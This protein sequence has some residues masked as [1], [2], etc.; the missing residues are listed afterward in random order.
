MS[1]TAF[2]EPDPSVLQRLL[3]NSVA[4]I[5]GAY[6]VIFALFFWGIHSGLGQYW[7]WSFPYFGDQMSTL[8]TNKS[9]S[10]TSAKMGSP[11][12]YSSDYFVRFVIA[13]FGFL[14]P[15]LTR[16]GLLVI[17]FSVGALGM[18]MLARKCTSGGMAF[19]IGLAAF[20]NPAMFYK[21]TAG[22]FNYFISYVLF[23]YL[24]LF[25]LYKFQKN[26]RSAVIVGLFLAFIGMQIQ[27]FVIGSIFVIVFLAFNR[28]LVAWRYV[29]VMVALPVL[30]N[31]VWLSNFIVGAASVA[32]TGAAATKV[33]F[34]SLGSS[35]F[36][37]IF[38][39]SFSGATLLNRF[40]VFYELLWNAALF[41]FLLW[42]LVREKQKQLIDV[43]L[44]VFLSIM[45][46]M[47]TGLYQTINLG[48]LTALYPMLREVGHF[49]PIIVLIALLLVSR[50]VH[51]TS[52]RWALMGILLGSLLIVGVKFQYY[53]QGYSFAFARSQFA[54]FKKIADK[55]SS[56]YRILAYPFFDQYSFNALPKDAPDTFPL[57]NSGHDSFAG[58]SKQGY[59]NNA[60]AP[61]QFQDSLQNRLLQ[62]YNIDMLKPYNIKYIFDLS[63][64]YESN[65]EKYVPP[66]V[67]NND[68]SLIKN[69]KH[70]LDKLLAKN[71]GKLK[72]LNSHAL[73]VT[74]FSPHVGSAD[75]VFDINTNDITAQSASIFTQEALNKSLN[76][77]TNKSTL[78]PYTTKLTSLFAD[79]AKNKT[80]PQAGTAAQMLKPA[81][82]SRSALYI[83]TSRS[84]VL[85]QA[86]AKELTIYTQ[87][88]GQLSLNGALVYNP[89]TKRRV[90]ATI[91]FKGKDPY[92][93][94]FRG[95]SA[96]I[97]PN[98]QGRLGLGAQGDVITIFDSPGTNAVQN[99]SFEQGLWQRAVHDCNNYRFD[100]GAKLGMQLDTQHT[101][102]GKQALELSATRHNAC[103]STPAKVDPN[104]EYLL[105]FDYQSSDART[106][107]F[108]LG[109]ADKITLA[110]GSQTITN[111]Q[112][113][114]Y[115]TLISTPAAVGNSQ[116]FLYAL[117][118][119]GQAI[120]NRYDNVSLLKLSPV[121]TVA[122]PAT[123]NP[124]QKIPLAA[125]VQNFSVSSEGQAIEN[126][127]SNGSFEKGAWQAQV[128]DCRNYDDA[129]K[130]AMRLDKTVKTGG[131]QSLE[132]TAAHHD[133]CVHTTTN[134]TAGIDYQLSFDYQG[135]AGKDYGY[136]ISFDDPL[137]TINRQQLPIHSSD[138][139]Q[140][141]HIRVHVPANATILTFYL[142]A[143]EPTGKT[144]NIVHYDNVSL[145]EF[146]D[147]ADT[148]YVT[149]E[150][151][152]TLQAP[153]A[154]TFTD[155]SETHKSVRIKGASKPFVLYLSETYHP[156]WRLEL[157][158]AS[159]DGI[160][161]SRLPSAIGNTV[162]QH[163]TMNNYQNAW[164]V[165]PQTLCNTG[166]GTLVAGCT[167]NSNGSYDIELT[168]EFVPQRWFG[169]SAA[170]SWLTILTGVIYL[171]ASRRRNMPTYQLPSKHRW[172][173]FAGK[174]K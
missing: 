11:L 3:H 157:T 55:D 90:L 76:Y 129:A 84:T 145:T 69:D 98:T 144:P 2:N 164:L 150:R 64:I 136:A 74:D 169:V 139:W 114:T 78:A 158:N 45:I 8:F 47:A 65:Y 42:L 36:L 163:F 91:P 30:I 170:I 38:T 159:V 160:I 111:D 43:G 5:F 153:R 82:D 127:I 174:G 116:L 75:T 15:E 92:F 103:T 171:T 104:S 162:S 131:R 141:A 48:P 137:N 146:P 49:A 72:R 148:F 135:K 66:S 6:F 113:G 71:P 1:Q 173:K 161:R 106:A 102:D 151:S 107:S 83:D 119:D 97:T 26:L 140:H 87:P 58:Y 32:G 57:K 21:Y 19:V 166:Q 73:E 128:S 50:M 23:I 86:T 118:Q 132:L 29:L 147:F 155:N 121:Q 130:V 115:T 9:A 51:K 117:G 52:W 63:A 123:H 88:S 96:T 108:Y 124:Y 105:T 14:P 27:F 33:S 122:V 60:I 67:Y 138:A 168:A 99:G 152:R 18:Y 28:T 59:I 143:Y 35:D 41:V 134:V 56:D 44:L 112:W 156:R 125:G 34:K 80:D 68:L 142:Y 39:F 22:H 70:F 167:K 93:V 101:S 17:I 110:K 37:S 4:R 95:T 54:P 7:D 81:V 24:L 149:E 53:S 25:L 79:P 133:A 126:H 109:D 16:Y 46:F 94:S 85:Y 13:M 120:T 31:L 100:T 20:V 40:Y 10:W 61:Y 89:G 12:G 172:H 62:T 165:D 77:V 154:T